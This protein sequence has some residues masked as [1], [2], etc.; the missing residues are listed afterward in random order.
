[1]SK[2]V[3]TPEFQEAMVSKINNAEDKSIAIVEAMEMMVAASNSDLVDSIVKE[4]NE[5]RMAA[6][7]GFRPL[8]ESE[9]K[10]YN[11]LKAGAKQSVTADQIDIIPVETI[12]WT[13]NEIKQDSGIT[14]LITFAPAGVKKWLTAS[15]TGTAAWGG[16][17]DEIV[18][19]LTATIEGTDM[20]AHKLSAFCLIPKAIRDLEIGYV[21]KYFTAILEEAMR[22]GIAAGY[23]YGDGKTAPIG[24]AKKISQVNQDGT[25]TAKT[26]VATVTGFSPAALAPHLK[27][28][29]HNGIRKIEKLFV[30]CNP[31][32]R[33]QYVNPALYGDSF[34]GGWVDK[35]FMPI[36][37]I[38]D[39]NVA[40]GDGF[41]T[42]EGVFTMGFQGVMVD[43]YKETKAIED[44]DLIIAK[45][46]G[47]G[48]AFDDD[49]AVYFNITKLEEYV[50]TVKNVAGAGE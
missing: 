30:I 14:R 32:D 16:L 13:L 2:N 48:R 43:E 19:E 1:M 45:V 31:L 41:L 23:L 3:F 26:K 44:C 15:K 12:D 24:L 36:E 46:Y 47:N 42:I 8:S 9:K 38:E 29:S 6:N 27:T 10:F 4:A 21:D 18:S 35:S 28:L 5:N 17:T 37:V 22:D 33:Y 34:V 39:A 40:Q 20:D 11:G 7:K 49:A 50:P 25:H